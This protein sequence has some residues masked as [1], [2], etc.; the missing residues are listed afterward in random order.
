VKKKNSKSYRKHRGNKG[1]QKWLPWLIGVLGVLMVILVIYNSTRKPGTDEPGPRG[2]EMLYG[3]QGTS[4][5]AGETEFVYPD[6]GNLGSGHKWLP[7][8]GKSDAPVTIIEFSDL[9]CG[10]C[11]TFNL[12]NLEGIL[13][14]YVETGKVRYIDHYFGFPGTIQ[15]GALNA[16]LC[17][18]EQGH[19][20]EFK[21]ALFQ[22]IEVNAFDMNRSAR[23]SGLD[24]QLYNEC[25]DSNRYQAAVQESVYE[26]NMG[27][28][29][30]PTFFINGEQVTGNRADEIRQKIESALAD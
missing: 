8:L 20:F 22:S 30:T 25:L 6:P 16:M 3:I 24:M 7:A 21:H 27:V 11:R 2:Y 1:Q 14:E 9:S 5:D 23:I 28:S 29:V 15:S 26:N 18:A 10:H 19:Y 17:A 13:N 4:Y 12:D